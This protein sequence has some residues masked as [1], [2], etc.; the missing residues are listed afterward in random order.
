MKRLFAFF[1]KHYIVLVFLLFCMI[2]YGYKTLNRDHIIVHYP[3]NGESFYIGSV[4]WLSYDL[5]SWEYAPWF[6]PFTLWKMIN[7]RYGEYGWKM[8]ANG[9]VDIWIDSTKKKDF[10]TDFVGW[11]LPNDNSLKSGW[12]SFRFDLNHSNF[13]SVNIYLN[14][15]REIVKKEYKNNRFLWWCY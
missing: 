14:E 7:D 11:W 9:K 1:K 4:Y 2:W 5:S 3:H 10:T 15:N 13:C 12:K 8:E 6:L